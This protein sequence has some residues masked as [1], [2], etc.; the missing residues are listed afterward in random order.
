MPALPTLPLVRGTLGRIAQQGA[1]FTA[2]LLGPSTVL[3]LPVVEETSPDCRAEL[4][5]ARCRVDLRGRV[6]RHRVVQV[7]SAVLTLEAPVSPNQFAFGSLFWIDGPLAGLRER[8]LSNTDSQLHLARTVPMPV[9]SG[10]QVELVEGCD[11]TISTCAARFGNAANFRGE[12]HL[13]GNDLL[14]RYVV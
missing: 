1:A 14:A 10:T 11:R 3:D 8:I 2:T 7:Q 5:D 6:Q 9:A 12:P 13:P 4:G